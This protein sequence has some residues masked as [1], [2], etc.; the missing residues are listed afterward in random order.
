MEEN[1]ANELGTEVVHNGSVGCYGTYVNNH[2][3]YH[4]SSL[5]LTVTY[6]KLLNRN[7]A[8]GEGWGSTSPSPKPCTP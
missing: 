1:T 7:A 6:F 4:I 8:Y 5:H 3:L 2:I